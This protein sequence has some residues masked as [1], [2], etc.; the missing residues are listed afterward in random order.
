MGQVVSN[1]TAEGVLPALRTLRE[2]LADKPEYAAG[3]A[4]L[5]TLLDAVD[6]SNKAIARFDEVTHA[7]RSARLSTLDS[8][9]NVP[10]QE[11]LKYY[12]AQQVLVDAEHALAAILRGKR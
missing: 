8:P 2:Q 7:M 1:H 5:S 6:S 12:G 3:A 9:W 4:A 11:T 10:V